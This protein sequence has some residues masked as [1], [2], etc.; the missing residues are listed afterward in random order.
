MSVATN[1]HRRPDRKSSCKPCAISKQEAKDNYVRK[2]AQKA[3]TLRNLLSEA[4]LEFNRGSASE[5]Q[6]IAFALN[7]VLQY[8][9]SEQIDYLKN[10][11]RNVKTARN[12]D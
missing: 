1:E 3:E 5:R 8:L 4:L 7:D 9:S 10:L 12:H 11:L 2:A 6:I